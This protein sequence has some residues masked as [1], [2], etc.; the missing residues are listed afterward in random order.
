MSAPTKPSHDYL[1]PAEALSN[2]NWGCN[3]ILLKP[4]GRPSRTLELPL[5]EREDW[6]LEDDLDIPIGVGNDDIVDY[7]E[8]RSDESDNFYLSTEDD[9]GNDYAWEGDDER[10]QQFWPPEMLHTP[11][12]SRKCHCK[13]KAPFWPELDDSTTISLVD[14]NLGGGCETKHPLPQHREGHCDTMQQPL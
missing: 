1:L 7:E 2:P 8:D 4:R 14:A 11:S 5:Q 9:D 6:T 13:Q 3:L 10:N 12:S